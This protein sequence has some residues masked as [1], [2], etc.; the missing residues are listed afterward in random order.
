M[1]NVTASLKIAGKSARFHQVRGGPVWF[2]VSCSAGPSFWSLQIESKWLATRS[3]PTPPPSP[4]FLLVFLC[5][6]DSAAAAVQVTITLVCVCLLN[7][8][9]EV[10]LRPCSRLL[11]L[12]RGP[13]MIFLPDVLTLQSDC[14]SR[15]TAGYVA[16]GE[17]EREA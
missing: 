17:T 12:L 2:R 6:I 3:T 16:E 13:R 10:R 11:I 4:L 8:T 5:Q 15:C 9:T 1:I 7:C 14:W